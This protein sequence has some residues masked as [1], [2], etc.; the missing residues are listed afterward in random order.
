MTAETMKLIIIKICF[1]KGS[2]ENVKRSIDD[3]MF[4]Y[5]RTKIRYFSWQKILREDDLLTNFHNETVL[6]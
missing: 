4:R 1:L 6:L 5:S 2:Y 3:E